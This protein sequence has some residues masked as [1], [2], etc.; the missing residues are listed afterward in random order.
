MQSRRNATE[1]AEVGPPTPRPPVRLESP[2]VYQALLTRR[3]LT[4]KV[5]PLLAA[6]AVTLCTA[7]VLITWSVMGGFLTMLLSSGRTLIGDVSIAW[8]NVG[9]AYYGDLIDRLEDDPMVK[10]AAPV[11]DTFGVLTLPDGRTETIQVR[12]IDPASFAKVTTY[13][14]TI[15][16]RP[17]DR[18]LPKDRDRL[19]IRLDERDQTLF[20]KLYQ[21]GLTLTE[22][23]PETGL[24]EPAVV[25]GIELSG[26]N[27][28]E[29][30][31]YYVPLMGNERKADGS[32][33][34]AGTFMPLDRVTLNVLP[35]DTRGR[36][37]DFE[38]RVFPVANEFQTGFYEVDEGVVLVRLDALQ[39][40]LKM[41]EARRLVAE[42]ED[43]FEIDLQDAATEV[44][45][46]RVTNVI[47]RAVDGVDADTLRD[48]CRVIY[49]EFATA[50][51]GEVPNAFRIRIGTWE[52]Q[53]RTLIAAVKK[54]TALVL[55]IFCFI[56]LTAVFLVLAIFWS[57]V[58]EKTRDVG[59]L[60]S[61]GASRL[62]VASVWLGYGTAIG[63]VGSALG[64]L[65]AYVI[66]TNINPIHD[67]LGETFN[68][69][70]WDPRVYYF[71]V[72]P[73]TVEPAKA[74]IVLVGGVLSS[75]FGALIPAW[76]AAAMDP[77]K[78]LRFE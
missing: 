74:A 1:Q 64:G 4:S 15:W 35:L 37:I 30:G 22:R 10:A 6:V 38:S 48:R 46:A 34:A 49:E 67:W 24:P 56:S 53:N 39:D 55:F 52:D 42:P 17:L 41:D 50:H 60:R 5:M 33:R 71:T 62:G 68:L 40:M 9:F 76:R 51:E 26:L 54:E 20:E 18:P 25:L 8:P 61:I 69:Y 3:Y 65:L 59:V 58:S 7:M 32:I 11:I 73:S 44:E 16:W 23:D 2:H 13:A 19:D 31:G 72:I 43:L 29:L 36:N 21:D 45:P 63:V 57:M 27:A 28:R 14:D 70:I 75:V 47:V 12:G 66:V 78:A 77:V